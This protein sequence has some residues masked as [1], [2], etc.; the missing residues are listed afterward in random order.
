LGGGQQRNESGQV[1]GLVILTTS[2][3]CDPQ[4]ARFT[5]STGWGTLSA[6]GSSNGAVDSNDHGDMVMHIQLKSHVGFEGLGTHLIEDLIVNETGECYALT[7]ALLAI[8]NARQRVV[9]GTNPAANQKGVLLL[10]P[11]ATPS[12]IDGDGA[13]DAADLAALLGAWGACRACDGDL[14]VRSRAS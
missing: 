13:M 2:T 3:C 5:E 1:T 4:V 14:N 11:V 12:A 6:C 7:L 9:S 10:T 8:S